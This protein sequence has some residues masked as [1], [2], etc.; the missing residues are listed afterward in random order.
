MKDLRI[1]RD[2]DLANL[3][4][5]D[6]SPY[7]FSPQI[8]NGIPIIPFYNNKKDRELVDL[9]RYLKKLRGVDDV[10]LNIRDTFRLG[11]V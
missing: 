5:I 7:S 2:R 1:F 9:T 11:E 8:D 10:R 4:L 6:N 3:I